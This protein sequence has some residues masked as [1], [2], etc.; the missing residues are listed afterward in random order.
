MLERLDAGDGGQVEADGDQPYGPRVLARRV[1][2]Q[3]RLVRAERDG[4]IRPQRLARHLAGVGVHAAGQVDG[5]DQAPDPRAAR[6]RGIG[7]GTQAA[8][9]ADAGDAVQYEVGGGQDV[10]RVVGDAAAGPLQGGE[11]LGV[12]AVAG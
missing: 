1:D 11:A 7:V 5:D 4:H 6:A 2:E 10:E 8:A 3:A 12:G 9:A